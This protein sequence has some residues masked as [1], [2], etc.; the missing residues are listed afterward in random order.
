MCRHK[1]P[2]GETVGMVV[3]VRSFAENHWPAN[4]RTIHLNQSPNGSSFLPQRDLLSRSKGP[5]EKAPLKKP[6]WKSPT[7]KAPLKRPHWKGP[8]EKAPLKKPHWKGP[9]VQNLLWSVE[10]S[11]KTVL[12]Q[13]YS[14]RQGDMSGS[15]YVT[16]T[17]GCVYC[18]SFRNLAKCTG[19][20]QCHRVLPCSH[21]WDEVHDDVPA[22]RR[23]QR[24]DRLNMLQ[25]VHLRFRA[26]AGVCVNVQRQGVVVGDG[27]RLQGMT[28]VKGKT[29]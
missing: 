14:L 29:V 15:W 20:A 24:D 19:N 6:H 23:I 13:E 4:G 17:N 8:T 22:P 2:L 10:F 28:E 5:T 25:I 12:G 18:F 27:T 7:E 9:T 11:V 26:L 3:V 16:S 21:G 1:G